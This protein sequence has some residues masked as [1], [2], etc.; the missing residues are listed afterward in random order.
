[1]AAPLRP[2]LPLPREL[3]DHIYG[4]LLNHESVQAPPYHSRAEG[5]RGIRSELNLRDKSV[6]HTYRFHT[7]TIAVDKTI[8]QEAEQEL[9]RTNI[10]VVVSWV[11]PNL[12]NTLHAFDL[13]IISENQ[14]VI[15]RFHHFA[16]RLHLRDRTPK[17]KLG[18]AGHVQS[19][20]MLH[21]DLPILCRTLRYVSATVP[22]PISIFSKA[23]YTPDHEQL[24]F[25]N[26]NARAQRSM[27]SLS[28]RSSHADTVAKQAA[29]LAPLEA[30]CIG[31]QKITVT[32]A[33]EDLEGEGT[34]H[35]ANRRLQALAA[36]ECVWI[37]VAAWDLLDI[38]A[39]LMS[40]ANKPVKCG[41]LTRAGEHYARIYSGTLEHSILG[42]LPEQILE[43]DAAPAI[44]CAL[45]LLSDAAASAGLL[46]LRN[47]EIR[48]ALE[49][50]HYTHGLSAYISQFGVRN[51][52]LGYEERSVWVRYAP[53]WHLHLLVDLLEAESDLDHLVALFSMVHD[54]LPE[55]EHIAHDLRLVSQMEEQQSVSLYQRS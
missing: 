20:L 14:S 7:N 1:M 17:S 3:R 30:M 53:F 49:V 44:I 55:N 34:M 22:L 26:K 12:G 25:T 27:I 19:L 8:R 40:A 54:V 31:G 41:D 50:D 15:A 47:L 46:H 48:R 16:L 23:A 18:S 5:E 36:P 28:S 6:V 52:V 42:G 43:S 21:S 13:P 39:A 51:E 38:A 33:F 37:K 4:Y 11:W 32:G 10:F 45:R 29:L 24:V 35:D 9:H 2:N